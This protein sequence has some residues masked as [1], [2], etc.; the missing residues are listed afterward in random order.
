MWFTWE[1]TLWC[2]LFYK[3]KNEFFKFYSCHNRIWQTC[4]LCLESQC[5]LYLC[6]WD[7][8]RRHKVWLLLNYVLCPLQPVR[9]S[10]TPKWSPSRELNSMFKLMLKFPVGYYLSCIFWPL[11]PV[12]KCSPQ[13]LDSLLVPLLLRLLQCVINLVHVAVSWIFTLS[14]RSFLSSLET[15]TVMKK[16]WYTPVTQLP[17]SPFFPACPKHR[18]RPCCSRLLSASQ[19]SQLMGYFGYQC[20]LE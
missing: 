7:R 20:S 3:W 12:P 19:D 2:R 8:G 13:G 10:F 14:L 6:L 11:R 9:T 15:H 16:R 5:F 18:P 4:R 17:P 1:S